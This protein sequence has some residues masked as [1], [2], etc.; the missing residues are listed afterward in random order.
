MINLILIILSVLCYYKASSIMDNYQGRDK[1]KNEIT[2]DDLGSSMMCGFM[3]MVFFL[4]FVVSGVI[5][6]INY[7]F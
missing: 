3:S 7:I 2:A 6:L 1:V 4:A 5:Q